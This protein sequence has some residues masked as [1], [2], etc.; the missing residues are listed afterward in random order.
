MLEQAGH[1]LRGPWG[2]AEK[3]GLYASMAGVLAALLV[4]LV[5][6]RPGQ[7]GGGR[8]ELLTDDPGPTATAES[9]PSPQQMSSPTTAASAGVPVSSSPA[10]SSAQPSPRPRSPS[11]SLDAAHLLSNAFVSKAFG[12]G[13]APFVG[14]WTGGQGAPVA[15]RAFDE[16]L[17][18]PT[19]DIRTVRTWSWPNEVVVG[20][21]LVV[22]HSEQAASERLK[23]CRDHGPGP[24]EDAP[25]VRALDAG[26]EG[27][28]AV[29]RRELFTQVHAGVRIGQALVLTFWRQSGQVT[30][31]DPLEAAMRAA[32]AKVMGQPEG[33]PV[34]AGPQRPEAAL[35]GFLTFD[36]FYSPDDGG[37]DGLNWQSDR[38]GSATGIDCTE[39]LSDAS[40]LWL[41]TKDRPIIR[42]WHGGV[43][44]GDDYQDATLMVGVAADH[45]TAVRDFAACFEANEASRVS[46]LGDEAFLVDWSAQLGSPTVFVRSGSTY[47]VL[48]TRYLGQDPIPMAR[49]ALDRYLAAHT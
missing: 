29:D 18:P 12:G 16:T 13:R 46:D 28:L 34:V 1:L 43:L 40:P 14:D 45:A 5:L 32:A 10:S 22:M 30:S 47:L 36:Q 4:L 26:D 41:S 21:T 27:F 35:R 44:N 24:R 23:Y 37:W 19:W 48:A 20:E 15:C 17:P 6:V 25:V 31:T 42:S 33:Q 11:P 49:L 38:R 8:N 2:G 39:P 7:D 3:R 9:T